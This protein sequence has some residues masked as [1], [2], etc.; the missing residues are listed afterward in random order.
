VSQQPSALPIE[1]RQAAWDALWKRLLSDPPQ[2]SE[3]PKPKDHD[4][5]EGDE[6][7]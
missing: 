6:A 5:D 3:P 4:E 7:A 1:A 2:D